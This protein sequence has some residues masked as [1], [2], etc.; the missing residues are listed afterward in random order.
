MTISALDVAKFVGLDAGESAA[1]V[2]V[3]VDPLT[4]KLGAHL[5]PFV[6]PVVDAE[7]PHQTV[8]CGCSGSGAVGRV[9]ADRF[10]S[11]RALHRCFEGKRAGVV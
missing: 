11:C 10:G 8:E 3:L 9:V 6:D 1:P 2:V 4:A 5:E 7:Y